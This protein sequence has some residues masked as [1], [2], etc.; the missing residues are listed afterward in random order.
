[1]LTIAKYSLN[2]TP[3][4][5]LLT[6]SVFQPLTVQI[7]NGVPTLWAIVDTAA[8]YKEDQIIYCVPTNSTSESPQ[9]GSNYLG[10]VQMA[11]GEMHYFV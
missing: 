10:T 6:P 7:Q 1:M 9:S 3:T 2:T 4:Q 5:K 8:P 11:S